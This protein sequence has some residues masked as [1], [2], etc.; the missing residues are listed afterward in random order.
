MKVYTIPTIS[1]IISELDHPDNAEQKKQAA[2][3][4][5]HNIHKI[6]PQSITGANEY[7]DISYY[8]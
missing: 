5:A 1:E 4:Q 6:Y 3:N 2:E 7:I 8:M